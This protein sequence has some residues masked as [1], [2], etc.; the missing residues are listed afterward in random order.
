MTRPRRLGVMA[1]L[2]LASVLP[3]RVYR[4]GAL[5]PMSKAAFGIEAG[6]EFDSLQ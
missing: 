6:T 3:A 1:M 2:T 5:A 4:S